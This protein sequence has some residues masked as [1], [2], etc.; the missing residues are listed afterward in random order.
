MSDLVVYDNEATDADVRHGQITQF[1]AIRADMDFNVLEDKNLRVRRLPWVVPSPKALEVTRM[2]PRSLSADGA[3]S[4]YVASGE[5]E[6]FL[7]PGYG[8]PRVMLTYNGLKFDDELLRTTLFR[9]LRRPWFSSDKLT[10]RVD[11]LSIVRLAHAIAPDSLVV[12]TGDEGAPTWKLERLAPANGIEME[13]H[14]ALSDARATLELA[15]MV[16]RR[17][18]A[19]WQAGLD[20]GKAS[21]VE[22][23]LSSAAAAGRPVYLFTHFGSAEI[24]PCAVIG[25]DGKKKWILADLRKEAHPS[26]PDEIADV[27][28]SRGTP[29]PVVRSNAAPIFLDAAAASRIDPGIDPAAIAARSMEIKLDKALRDGAVSALRE[30]PYSE[31]EVGLTSEERIYS[32]FVSDRERPTMTSF[33]RAS[34]WEEKL[35]VAASFKDPRLVDFSARIIIDACR[36]G[37]ADLPHDSVAALE[38]AC[39]EALFRPWAGEGARWATLSS[40][41]ASGASEDWKAWAC[42][43]FGGLPETEASAPATAEPE[44]DGEADEADGPRQFELGF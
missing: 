14:D 36:H 29:F 28:F 2:D 10:T 12:P 15:K 6:K 11:L 41:I 18:P 26:A 37:E 30:R 20:C 43:A 31:P 13:A 8:V 17:A 34:T 21:K 35:N 3:V 27:I 23:L 7:V 44:K 24:V 32:G 1:G 22:E 4:E 38:A 19:A 16:A 42:E 33:H 9:N 39:S 5:I 40:A 25:T